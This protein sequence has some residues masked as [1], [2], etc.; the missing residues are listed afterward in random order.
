MA[1]RRA[2][3]LRS[4][5]R[6]ALLRAAKAGTD[7][8]RQ[9][10]GR[11]DEL[12]PLH[13][14]PRA[15]HR[16]LSAPIVGRTTGRRKF[17]PL[18]R[19]RRSQGGRRAALFRGTYTMRFTTIICAGILAGIAGSALACELP[20]IPIIPP[21]DEVAGKE[22]A[23]RTAAAAYFTAMQAYTACVQAELVGAGGDAAPDLVKRVFVA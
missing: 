22:A 2:P 12:P 15:R 23:L 3:L 20:K 16:A 13:V 14:F 1:P 4:R 11:R 7:R 21:K 18:C 9:R 5:G 19:L 10:G 8:R 6:A 17:R